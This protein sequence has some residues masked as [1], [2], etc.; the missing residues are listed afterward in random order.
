MMKPFNITAMKNY[1]FI[2]ILLWTLPLLT[3]AQQEF[4]EPEDPR[5]L[6]KNLEAEV[7][8]YEDKIQILVWRNEDLLKAIHTLELRNQQLSQYPH[9][10][11]RLHIGQ[12]YQEIRLYKQIIDQNNVEL[13]NLWKRVQTL[14][15][16]AY[17]LE[18]QAV[19]KR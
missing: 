11:T 14:S 9:S 1:A 8:L 18:H 17:W 2:F 12:N 19:T 7:A 15:D 16:K 3:Q 5:E 13:E 10:A 4:F 6:L